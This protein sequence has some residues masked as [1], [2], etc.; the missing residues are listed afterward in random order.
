MAN[1]PALQ[2]FLVATLQGFPF[3]WKTGEK[4]LSILS[5]GT[6]TYTKRF[7]PHKIAKKGLLGW[8]KM[9]PE[10]FME[11]ANYMNQT[12]LQYLSDSATAQVINREVGDLKGDL[13]HKKKALN[14]TRYN[15]LL[16][17][18]PMQELGFSFSQKQ[19]ESLREMSDAHNKDILYKI[20]ASAA[21]KMV[22]ERDIH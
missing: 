6:G 21:E 17:T 14:Y 4:N 22:S 5:I 11:D 12:I 16:E 10:L 19:L 18:N 20:G 7:N 3:H 8:A 9:I 15:V 13:L 1:N 2:L